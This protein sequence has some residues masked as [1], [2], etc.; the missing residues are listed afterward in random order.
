MVGTLH[1]SLC[2]GC[3]LGKTRLPRPQSTRVPRMTRLH[4]RLDYDHVAIVLA[5]RTVGASVQSLADVGRGCPDLLVGWHGSNILMEI[6]SPGAHLTP[7][8]KDWHA[9]WT[10]REPLVR[11]VSDAL[12]ELG[13]EG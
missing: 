2:Q 13:L 3:Q 9:H 8:E 12:R 6:K 11:G 4:G 5:L 10:A 1:G 7:A